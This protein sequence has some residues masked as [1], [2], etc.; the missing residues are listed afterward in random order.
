[1]KTDM[2][3]KKIPTQVN[4]DY[5]IPILPLSKMKR[6]KSL[7]ITRPNIFHVKEGSL[8][9]R[10]MKTEKRNEE[11]KINPIADCGKNKLKPPFTSHSTTH[12]MSQIKEIYSNRNK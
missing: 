8:T 10:I 4:T 6:P 2:L 5:N 1:M 9:N 11:I 7:R 3:R 12:S